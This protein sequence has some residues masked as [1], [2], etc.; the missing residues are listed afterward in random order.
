MCLFYHMNK[1]AHLQC[2]LFFL[3]F[4]HFP[5]YKRRPILWSTTVDGFLSLGKENYFDN[6]PCHVLAQ[7]VIFVEQ[8]YENLR[9]W[10]LIALYNSLKM[11][12]LLFLS[13]SGKPPSFLGFFLKLSVDIQLS[14]LS[15]SR[16]HLL[17]GDS[18]QGILFLKASHSC[19]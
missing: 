19:P 8:N 14:V 7:Q 6:I 11:C 16:F 17:R 5:K 10:V 3:R 2:N 13:T 1:W 18:A 9:K 4:V 15:K 12:Y